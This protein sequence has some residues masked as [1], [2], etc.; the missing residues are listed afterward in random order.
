[1]MNTRL[2][3]RL[4]ETE[5]L[6]IFSDTVEVNFPSSFRITH[7]LTVCNEYRQQLT[8]TISHLL[9]YI[10]I[11]KCVKTCLDPRLH[12]ANFCGLQTQ[13]VEN[14]LLTPPST[15]KLCDFGSTTTPLYNV[16]SAV[17]EIQ[18]LEAEI[19]KTTTLQ[20]RAPELVDVWG[21]KG[22]DEKVGESS[23]HLIMLFEF[24]SSCKI[25]GTRYMGAWSTFVQAL[26]LYHPFRGEWASRYPQ[27]YLQS[28]LIRSPLAD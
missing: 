3:N 14:I 12:L 15:Y 11:S 8:C 1:M 6:K 25:F 24:G 26:L 19:N 2:Q 23:D 7:I 27:C 5:I 22:F 17:A 18:A 28:R 9:S 4:T 21:R 10:E 13:Q 16:P 20:Y